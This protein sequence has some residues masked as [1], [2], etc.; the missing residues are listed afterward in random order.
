MTKPP[1]RAATFPPA[2]PFPKSHPMP[3][4][5]G[6]AEGWCRPRGHEPGPHLMKRV[7]RMKIIS[8]TM[9][10]ASHHVV[11]GSVAVAEPVLFLT[12]SVGL[13]VWAGVGD[14]TQRVQH[15]SPAPRDP[16]G[17]STHPSVWSCPGAPPSRTRGRILLT[18][19][20]GQGGPGD[21]DGVEGDERRLQQP[22]VRLSILQTQ[23]RV[24]RAGPVPRGDTAT[25]LPGAP[26]ATSPGS[27]AGW[28]QQRR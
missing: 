14:D 26:P 5:S 18:R 23:G 12:S 11:S 9:L 25:S 20:V 22:R 10:G 19:Y 3:L 13:Q 1:H 24:L 21:V 17:H 6:Q 16:G 28:T 4:C 2:P 15:P 8:P 27:W 7:Q